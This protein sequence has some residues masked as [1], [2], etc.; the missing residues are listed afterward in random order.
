[1]EPSNRTSPAGAAIWSP[2]S[3]CEA[4]L[5]R[6]PGAVGLPGWIANRAGVR[7]SSQGRSFEGPV[8]DGLL[9]RGH[10]PKRAVLVTTL[11]DP[12][13]YSAD[14]IANLYLHRWEIEIDLRHLKA[15]MG[16]DVLPGKTPDIVH[17]EIW[18]FLTTYN[19]I[20]TVMWQTGVYHDIPPCGTEFQRDAP[21]AEYLARAHRQRPLFTR[22][23]SDGLGSDA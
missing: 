15:V 22:G 13:L 9:L 5:T 10:R 11:L 17:K 1:M 2:D 3:G 8:P 19:V 14:D 6:P 16:M 18:A 20:R 12:L 7:N 23:N 21:T 4:G